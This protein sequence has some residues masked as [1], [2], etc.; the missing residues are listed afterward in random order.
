MK[1]SE[2]HRALKRRW[3]VALLGVLATVALCVMTSKAVPVRYHASAELV[4]LPPIANVDS[5]G[6]PYLALGGLQNVV[7]VLSRAMTDNS[8]VRTLRVNGVSN[9]YVVARDV[10]S[11]GP[12]IMIIADEPTAKRALASVRTIAKL[13]PPTLLRLQQNINVSTKNLITSTTVR[14]DDKATVVSKSQTRALIV[15][16]G[17]GLGFTLFGTALVDAFIMRRQERK[18]RRAH[19][20]S[21]RRTAATPRDAEQDKPAEQPGSDEEASAQAHEPDYLLTDRRG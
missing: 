3:Y 21:R 14:S 2:L 16:A 20:A 10:N 12:L 1:L 17:A 5:G 11:S 18:R 7:D 6:N 4:L 9:R 13:I 19:T 8:A 15:A